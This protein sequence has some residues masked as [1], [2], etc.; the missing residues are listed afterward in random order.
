L[1]GHKAL[2]EKYTDRDIHNLFAYLESLQ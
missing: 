1:A 2:L